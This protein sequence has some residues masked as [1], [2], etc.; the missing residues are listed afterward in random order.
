MAEAYLR[1]RGFAVLARNRAAGG[2]EVDIVARDG[3]ALVFVEVRCRAEDSW[4]TAS[5]SIGALKRQRLRRCAGALARL[6]EFQW[7]Q[8]TLRVDVVAITL[9]ADGAGLRHLRGV[10]LSR[11]R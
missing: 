5:A 9:S 1:L 4:T 10:D 2:G 11:G 6:P 8:R 3:A 7:S